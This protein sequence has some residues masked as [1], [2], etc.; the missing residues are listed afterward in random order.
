MKLE[1]SQQ[2]FAK[3][4]NINLK[5]TPLVGVELF[6]ADGQTDGETDVT[7][8]TVAFRNFA[9]SPKNSN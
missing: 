2:M 7:R 6:L 3:D 5:K 8:L 1:F 9:N 4:S